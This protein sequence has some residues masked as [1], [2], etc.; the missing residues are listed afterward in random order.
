VHLFITFD[1]SDDGFDA[2]RTL[3]GHFN[4]AEQ[5]RL[6][7]LVVMWPQRESPIWD[8]ALA[9]EIDVDDLHRAMAEVASAALQRVRG[10]FPEGTPFNGIAADGDPEEAILAQIAAEKPDLV[11]IGITGGLRSRAVGRVVRQTMARAKRVIIVA[12]GADRTPP[13]P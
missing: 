1:G 4:P 11:V 8:K 10:L 6:T 3:L 2:L 9:R 12:H 7:A 13:A 5:W